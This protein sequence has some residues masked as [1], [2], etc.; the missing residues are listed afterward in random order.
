MPQIPANTAVSYSYKH[1]TSGTNV[2]KSGSG[3]LISFIVNSI[4]TTA[5]AT[6]FASLS[7]TSGSACAGYC[8]YSVVASDGTECLM[9]RPQ[10]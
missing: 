7:T 9:F 1:I 5:T 10:T 6:T 8:I 3:A 2:I 4:G